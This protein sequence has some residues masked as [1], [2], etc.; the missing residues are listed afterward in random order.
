LLFLSILLLGNHL[1]A[2]D[3]YAQDWQTEEDFKQ[4]EGKVLESILWLEENPIATA[5]NDTKARTEYVL[6]WLTNVPYLSV[7]YDEIFLAGLTNSKK[8]KFAEKFRVTYLFGKS[9]YVIN[10]P[11]SQDEV[12]ASTRGI[13][14][15]VKVYQELLKVDPSV[16]HKILEKYSRLAKKNKLEG[17]ALSNLVKENSKPN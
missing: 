2:Q 9:C 8:Y 1:Q 3:F 10:H 16:E 15:M 17:Y 6:N 12:K 11:D 14:G 5:T 7:T 4:A 13:E